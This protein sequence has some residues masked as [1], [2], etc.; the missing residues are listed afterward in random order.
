MGYGGLD[1]ALGYRLENLGVK[2]KQ[3]RHRAVC[4]HLHH[5]RPYRDPAVVRQNREILERIRRSGEWRAR[6]GIAELGADASLRVS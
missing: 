2:G 3:I 5:D 4:L 1:R 6:R